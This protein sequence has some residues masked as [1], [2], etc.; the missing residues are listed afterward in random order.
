MAIQTSYRVELL[1]EGEAP[2]GILTGVTGGSLSFSAAATIKSQGTINVTYMP[3]SVDLLN[4]RVKIILTVG[5]VDYPAGVYKLAV[6]DT[7][8]TATGNTWAIQLADKLSLLDSESIPGMFSLPAGANV[9]EEVKALIDGAGE[10][11]RAIT[12]SDAV[13]RGPVVWKPGTS[14]LRIINDLLDAANF[15][16]LW[17]DGDGQYRATPYQDPQRRPLAHQFIDGENCEYSPEFTRSQDLDK[18]PNRYIAVSRSSENEPALVAIAVNN[19]PDSQFSVPSRNN[20]FYDAVEEDIEF[21]DQAAGDA[22]AARR[23]Q[24]LSSAV[25]NIT[26]KH[27]WTPLNLNDAVRFARLMVPAHVQ[28]DTRCVVQNMDVD[29]G[30]PS[31]LTTTKL[32]EVVNV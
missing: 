12:S 15:L 14:R 17:C 24:D 25:A 1:G 27:A 10:H 18:I 32:R 2:K 29:L 23:L 5:G 21:T 20:K 19:N 26:I 3:A 28:I 7:G 16:A 13:L 22:Y 9:I 11:S 30:S 31:F 8:Y 6:P 4:D